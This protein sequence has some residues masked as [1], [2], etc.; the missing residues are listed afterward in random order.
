MRRNKTETTKFDKKGNGNT[1]ETYD[2]VG[3]AFCSCK[4]GYS[5]KDC[6][7]CELYVLKFISV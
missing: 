4:G 1:T 7:Y 5:G 6:S 2:D 3:D